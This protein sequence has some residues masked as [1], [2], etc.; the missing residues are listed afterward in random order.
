MNFPR[1]FEVNKTLIINNTKLGIVKVYK[2]LT[3]QNFLIQSK[4]FETLQIIYIKC[5][6]TNMYSIQP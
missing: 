5:H 3:F 6:P 2:G 1:N 4:G